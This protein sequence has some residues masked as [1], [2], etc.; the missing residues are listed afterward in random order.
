MKAATFHTSLTGAQ[1]AFRK[2]LLPKRQK[3]GRPPTDRRRI[4]DAILYMIKGGIPWRLRPHSFPPWKTVYH[5]VRP[6][7]LDNTWSG[8]TTACGRTPAKPRA[9]APA[10][11]PPR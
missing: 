8:S 11:P 10:P 6:W 4:M 5:I 7:T 1:W 3:R 2:R 9:N